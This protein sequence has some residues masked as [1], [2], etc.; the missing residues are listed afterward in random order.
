MR[1]KNRVL[2]LVC[3]LWTLLVVVGC[4]SKGPA[5]LCEGFESYETVQEVQNK[6][7]Q[8]GMAEHWAEESTGTEPSDW[9]PPLLTM[10]GPFKS[11]GI[12]GRLRLTFFSGRL[13]TTQFLTKSGQEYMAALKRRGAELPAKSATEITIYRRTVFRY[14]WF[15]NTL[16]F[17]WEDSKLARELIEWKKRHY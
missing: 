15:D 5:R 6:I 1:L 9:R 12:D 13:M 8:S 3:P 14:D 17:S 11:L 10:S 4:T 2:L 16:W 7:S